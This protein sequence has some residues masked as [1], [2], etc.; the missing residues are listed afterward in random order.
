GL[1]GAIGSLVVRRLGQMTPK[2]QW[3][4]PSLRIP[5]VAALAG[6]LGL[7]VSAPRSVLPRLDLAVVVHVLAAGMWAGG[8]MALASRRP[9]AGRWRASRPL[10][11]S[12]S[13]APPPSLPPSRLRHRISR[14]RAASRT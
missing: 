9:P 4:N 8:I 14:W 7:V 2:I 13:W 3:A 5:L 10:R 12:S 6:V 11:P 1:L